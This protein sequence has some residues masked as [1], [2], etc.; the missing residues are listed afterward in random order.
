MTALVQLGHWNVFF[1]L[2]SFT[3]SDASP[4]AWWSNAVSSCL[5]MIGTH[6]KKNYIIM[7]K[8]PELL[9]QLFKFVLHGMKKKGGVYTNWSL[10]LKIYRVNLI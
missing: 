10:T 4:F 1:F 8:T 5:R 9:N 7:I 6:C 3:N 2:L